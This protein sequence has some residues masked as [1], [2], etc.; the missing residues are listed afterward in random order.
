M[1]E[2]KRA[3]YSPSPRPMSGRSS[4]LLAKKRDDGPLQVP[5]SIT[6]NPTVSILAYCAASISMTIINKYC[7]SGENFNLNF[8]FLAVQVLS[9]LNNQL[10][11]ILTVKRT[12]GGMHFCDP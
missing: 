9:I 11:R 8:F 10:D 12:V 6:S 7:V 4:P 2:K 5:S 1:E 3:E